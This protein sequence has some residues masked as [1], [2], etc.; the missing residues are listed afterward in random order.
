MSP[1]IRY[2]NR[3]VDSF[4]FVA[5]LML[6]WLMVAV[7]TSVLIR[8]IGAQPPAWLFTSTEY[9]MFYLTLLGAPWLVREKGHVFIEVAITNLPPKALSAVSRLVMLICATISFVLAWKGLELLISNIQ[10]GDY[11]VRTYFIPMWIFT[12]AYPLSFGLMGIEFARF[13]FSKNTFHS[14]QNGDV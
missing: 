9:A 11:D 4:A 3:L 7:V 12:V 8:N 5:G 1:F 13:I 14:C 2:Y 6:I 10:D